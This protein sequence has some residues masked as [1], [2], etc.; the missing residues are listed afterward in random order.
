MTELNREAFEAIVNDIAARAEAA[1]DAAAAATA[2]AQSAEH[3]AAAAES[4]IAQLQSAAADA[5]AAP[6]AA[7]ALH[8]NKPRTKIQHPPRYLGKLHSRNEQSADSFL[9]RL[10]IYFSLTGLPETEWVT[11]TL[12]YLDGDAADWADA[13]Y[14]LTDAHIGV[15]FADFSIAF[16][17][18]FGVVNANDRARDAIVTLRQTSS[19]PAYNALFTRALLRIRDMSA[20]EQFDR[21]KRGLKPEPAK[22]VELSGCDT[23]EE[24]MSVADRIDAI[25]FHHRPRP[26]SFQAPRPAQQYYNG[27]TPMQLGAMT[28]NTGFQRRAPL[29]N[30]G[31][32][33]A[34]A[35]SGRMRLQPNDRLQFQNNGGCFYCRQ[36]DHVLADCPIRPPRHGANSRAPGNGRP[37]R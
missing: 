29:V 20:A 25:S 28:P 7:P 13:K 8:H 26:G 4:R 30:S 14:L 21:Y 22:Q 10:R 5:A 27:P 16:K 34:P 23:L 24:A 19:V 36:F 35:S 2:A 31:R 37:R 17:A 18:R 15:N 32:R 3:R 6:A 9:R 33:P 1:Q 12:T 11:T